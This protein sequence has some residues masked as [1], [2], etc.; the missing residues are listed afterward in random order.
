M[1]KKK[2]RKISKIM[3]MFCALML[4]FGAVAAVSDGAEASIELG[5]ITVN[6]EIGDGPKESELKDFP[7]SAE[8]TEN[9]EITLPEP[10]CTNSGFIFKYWVLVEDDNT[11]TDSVENQY[12]AGSKYTLPMGASDKPVIFR[13]VW[14]VKVTFDKNLDDA[15]ET[16]TVPQEDEV[17][18]GDTYVLDWTKSV[19]TATNYNFL[20]WSSETKKDSADPEY[21]STN[22]NNEIKADAPIKLY[23]IWEKNFLTVTYHANTGSDT[24][25][26]SVT[27]PVDS[28]KYMGENLTVTI[29]GDGKLATNNANAATMKD[30][31]PVRSG[32]TFAGWATSASSKTVEYKPG[33]KID[34]ITKDTD[35]YAVWTSSTATASNSSTSSGTT[36]TSKTP[37][38]G[39][40]DYLILY[41]VMAVLS[42]VGIIYLCYDQKKGKATK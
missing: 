17:L 12:N 18:F 25:D 16:V 4:V 32:Y 9:T 7:K 28:T 24:T 2:L 19:A 23:A 5:K 1:Q 20:G 11:N 10:T 36:S 30:A 41:I 21:K 40:N 33:S 14:A 39:D 22:K 31:V 37:Q 8:Y 42:L 34:P 38:T 13:A 29:M 15:T 6:F 26:S 27:V 35:L 3:M